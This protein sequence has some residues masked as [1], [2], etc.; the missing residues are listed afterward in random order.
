M[1]FSYFLCSLS[2]V[3][4]QKMIQ[5]LRR[6]HAHPEVDL[7]IALKFQMFHF[8]EKSVVAIFCFLKMLNYARP[9]ENF[10]S[11]LAKSHAHAL[12]VAT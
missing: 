1:D 6:S 8:V 2:H 3:V 7:Q 4:N 10:V 9:E 12:L 5:R 11:D